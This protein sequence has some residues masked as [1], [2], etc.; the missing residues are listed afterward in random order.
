MPGSC[1]DVSSVLECNKNDGR[2]KC[3]LPYNL[4][5]CVNAASLWSKVDDN[6]GVLANNT[7][8]CVLSLPKKILSLIAALRGGEIAVRPL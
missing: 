5:R 1:S 6:C 3:E 4:L 7:R 8:I 2:E